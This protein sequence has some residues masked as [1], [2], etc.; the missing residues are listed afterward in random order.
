MYDIAN[1]ILERMKPSKE[2]EYLFFAGFFIEGGDLHA[3]REGE[4]KWHTG[5][6]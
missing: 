6:N 3:P 5:K 1:T 4:G 2:Q